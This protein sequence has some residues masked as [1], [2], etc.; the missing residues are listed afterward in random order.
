MAKFCPLI[1]Q[2]VLYTE[3]LECDKKICRGNNTELKKKQRNQ[4]TVKSKKE[5]ESENNR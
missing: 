2:K 4:E 3:C 5:E 1:N